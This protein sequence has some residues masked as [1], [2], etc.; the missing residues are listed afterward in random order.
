MPACADEIATESSG[1]E[2][3]K[4]AIVA[5]TIPAGIRAQAARLTMPRIKSSPPPPAQ[6]KPTKSSVS[7]S[8]IFPKKF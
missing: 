3:A 4:A 1:L 2:V 7:D 6:S 5:P 8:V